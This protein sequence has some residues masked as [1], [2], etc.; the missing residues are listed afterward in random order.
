MVITRLLVH[1]TGLVIADTTNQEILVSLATIIPIVLL[2]NTSQETLVIH[3]VQLLGMVTTRLLV[4]VIGIVTV[5][6]TNQ[7][8]PVSQTTTTMVQLVNVVLRLI[9]VQVDTS[10]ISAW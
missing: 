2:D 1:V 9:L 10:Q 8:I 5:A 4:R 7:E 6:T 3:V